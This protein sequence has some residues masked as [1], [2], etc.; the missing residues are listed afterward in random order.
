MRLPQ[1]T[2]SALAAAAASVAQL[3][4]PPAP[5]SDAGTGEGCDPVAPAPCQLTV[6][7]DW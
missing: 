3:A 1:R 6:T 4:V 2:L 5:A 7:S